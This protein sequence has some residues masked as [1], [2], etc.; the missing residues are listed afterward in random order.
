MSPD[1][2]EREFRMD[3]H[4]RAAKRLHTLAQDLQIIA[5]ALAMVERT[6]SARYAKVL[7]PAKSALDR[8]DH[9]LRELA[10]RGDL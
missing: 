2:G 6:D 10:A 3:D 9:A 1:I 4:D 7:E 8:L 5:I